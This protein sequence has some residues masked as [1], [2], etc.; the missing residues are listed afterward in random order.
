MIGSVGRRASR[1]RAGGRAAVATR[2][3]M[4][5]WRAVDAGDL[6]T[7][8][9]RARFCVIR[10]PFETPSAN[11]AP[12]AR[13]GFVGRRSSLSS[14]PTGLPWWWAPTPPSR[15][16]HLFA[17]QRKADIN[18]VLLDARESRTWSARPRTSIASRGRSHCENF[19][20]CAVP[21]A[22]WSHVPRPARSCTEPER[23]AQSTSRIR[24]SSALLGSRSVAQGPLARCMRVG[25]HE[26]GS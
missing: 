26:P 24:M 2:T 3:R 20:A 25:K 7:C 5:L 14:A 12:N 9:G 4:R 19:V 21:L 22:I 15:A 10:C 8:T 13:C 1:P 23:A 11:W 17:T 6:V 16:E 18:S